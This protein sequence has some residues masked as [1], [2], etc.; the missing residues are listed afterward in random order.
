[1]SDGKGKGKHVIL[2]NAEGGADTVQGKGDEVYTYKDWD[3]VLVGKGNN[4][5]R[6]SG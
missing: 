5:G 4:V 6:D 2:L 1:M 3:W